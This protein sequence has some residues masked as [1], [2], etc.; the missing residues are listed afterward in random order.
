MKLATIAEAVRKTM[1]NKGFDAAVAKK[2]KTVKTDISK[3]L[4]FD[5]P[6]KQYAKGTFATVYQHP[7]EDNLL[8]K[9]TAHKDDIQNSVRAQ[10]LNSPN[11]VKLYPWPNGKLYQEIPELKTYAMM[12]QKIVGEPIAYAT[13]ALFTLAYNGN[14]DKA[15][16]WLLV[17]GSPPQNKMLEHYGKNNDDE[18]YKLADLFK[19]LH[20]LGK[21]GIHLS[22]L[23][24]NIIDDGTKY[25]IIDLGF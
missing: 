22:D 3:L 18:R 14:Y 1:S 19:A 24:Q 5:A 8:I 10:R 11:I 25:V 9:I 2:E 16:D 4:G 17:G 21:I 20:G 12:P 13:N 15:K 6:L 7:T 23:D